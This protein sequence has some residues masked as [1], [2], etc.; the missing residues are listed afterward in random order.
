MGLYVHIPFCVARCNYCD[1]ASTAGLGRTWQ[2]RYKKAV[3]KEWALYQESQKDWKA[4][5]ESQKHIFSGAGTAWET[6]YF[7]G[8]TPTYLNED[9]LEELMREL[10]GAPIYQEFTVEANPGS[11]TESKLHMLR[12]AGCSRLSVGAQSFDDKYLAWL[13]RRHTAEGFRQA[14]DMAQASGFTNMNLDLM[15]GLPGQP[16]DNWRDTLE[17]ALTYKP[18]HISLYQLNIEEGTPLA[19]LSSAGEECVADEEI[20]C[21]QY[22][23]AHQILTEAGYRHYE[24]SNYAKAGFESR[25]NTLYWRNG[26]YLGLGAG[27]AGHLPGIRYTNKADLETYCSSLERSVSPVAEKE[28]IDASL[29]LKDELMLAFRLKE[30]IQKKPFQERW[31]FALEQK[32]GSALEKHRAAGMLEEDE[33]H[34]VP[35]LQGWLHYNS[36]I[37]DF[38]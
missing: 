30:G 15:Y 7:G 3:L 17:E 18:E 20:C 25:H 26:H 10:V 5:R 14:W 34:V 27:A 37:L 9:I 33:E 21:K 13:G 35:T 23:Q 2:E 6:V 22:G 12:R 11:L 1:F 16:P 19:W 8:G 4:H 32:Y 36:W 24:I 29:A 28:E 38:L 31:G